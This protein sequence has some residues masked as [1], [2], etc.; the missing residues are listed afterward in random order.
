VSF[1]SV[2]FDVAEAMLASAMFCLPL[3]YTAAAQ[4]AASPSGIQ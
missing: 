2:S 4:A 1:I 3:R